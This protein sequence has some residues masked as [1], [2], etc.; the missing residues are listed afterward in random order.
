MA[1]TRTNKTARK[2][3]ASDIAESYERFKEHEG[4]QYT[5]V[6]VGRGHKWYYDKG[7]W[8]EKK[9]TPDTWQFTYAVKKRR[10]GKAPQ[11]SGAPVGTEYHW[12]ILAHQ[13]VK[14]LNA[15]DY[16]T[17]M[18]GKKYKIAHKRAEK[19]TWSASENARQKKLLTILDEMSAEL[20]AQIAQAPRAKSSKP[21]KTAT[22]DNLPPSTRR[23]VA[24]RSRRSH[25]RAA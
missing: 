20:R 17:E 23:S 8:K 9:I 3:R 13:T 15:N 19:E 18:S 25:R 11:G 22:K 5:G 7:E 16:T 14:K 1:R 2:V 24:S 21:S 6:K 12:Y 4:Q 10:A